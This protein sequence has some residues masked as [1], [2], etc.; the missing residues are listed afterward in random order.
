MGKKRYVYP[1]YIMKI[2]LGRTS[3]FYI[4]EV[5]PGYY[6]I[7]IST[8]CEERLRRHFRKLGFIG[9]VRIFDCVYDSV[10]LKTETLL[11]RLTKESGDR[12]T[13]YGE[14]EILCGDIDKHV[15][16]VENNIK[17]LLLLPQPENQR[18]KVNLPPVK[19]PIVIDN[20]VKEVNIIDNTCHL[21]NKTFGRLI[22]LQRHENRKT[23]CLILVLTPEQAI[24]PNRCTFC[25]KTFTNKGHLTRHHTTCKIK[26]I[27]TKIVVN[28]VNYE[29]ELRILKE[30]DRQRD[31]EIKLIKDQY[32]QMKEQNKILLMRVEKLGKNQ[33]KK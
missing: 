29:Q 11:K 3:C 13:K 15:A 26:N 18:C 16:W 33:T 6:K 12:I 19:M 20:H 1:D 25:N 21:C 31:V 28:K 8:R 14:T 23:P 32:N 17:K 2:K 4:I 9:I 30:K 10:M 22:D 27:G 5:E 7:G 24:N